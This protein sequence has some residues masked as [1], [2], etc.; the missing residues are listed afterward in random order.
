MLIGSLHG[1]EEPEIQEVAKVIEVDFSVRLAK[2]RL[3]FECGAGAGHIGFRADLADNLDN[4]AL[5]AGSILRGQ[6]SRAAAGAVRE[7]VL[8]IDSCK[9]PFEVLA[10]V[11]DAVVVWIE[12]RLTP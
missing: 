5:D 10:A 3:P 11:G 6:G 8:S 2:A 7:F 4:R 1:S 12:I 9:G